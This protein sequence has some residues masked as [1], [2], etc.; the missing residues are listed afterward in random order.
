MRPILLSMSL[1]F[2]S[3]SQSLSQSSFNPSQPKED[4]YTELFGKALDQ[5]TAENWEAA[6]DYYLQALK[7]RPNDAAAK[8]R[9]KDALVV[10]QEEGGDIE[11]IRPKLSDQLL[12]ELE[13][14]GL[15]D[16]EDKSGWIHQVPIKKL[17]LSLLLSFFGVFGLILLVRYLLRRSEE[18]KRMNEM[19]Q[20]AER[21]RKR[22]ERLRKHTGEQPRPDMKTFQKKKEDLVV[23][24]K[25][26][27]EMD[28]LFAGVSSL[29]S[30]MKRP[31]FAE[32]DE[33]KKQE[34]EQSDLIASL[35]STLLSQVE[36]QTA[37]DG[38]KLSKMSLDAS[39]I[40]DESDVEFFEKEFEASSEDIEAAKIKEKKD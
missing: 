13:R 27:E 24:E 8:S 20:K 12:G 21:E 7:E 38:K 40:F 16:I 11:L 23:T 5:E 10:Y 1:F 32:M 9:L 22:Q 35:A 17:G 19:I 6:I 14:E 33:Q 39:L 2:L 34:L 31:E 37:E 15:L 18:K 26:K 28:D 4:Q 36:T 30:E 3:F 29:T 25:T